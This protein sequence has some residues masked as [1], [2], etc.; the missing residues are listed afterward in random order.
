MT[1]YKLNQSISSPARLNQEP[2]RKE[3]DETILIEG[4]ISR[5]MESWPLQ[6]MVETQNGCYAVGLLSE[7]KV[8]RWGQIADAGLLS[9]GLQVKI[10]GQPSVIDKLAMTAQAI[11]MIV[12]GKTVTTFI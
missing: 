7:T 11:E 1:N 6:L 10:Q 12:S 8:T 5:V 4:K 9:C 3:I 2:I